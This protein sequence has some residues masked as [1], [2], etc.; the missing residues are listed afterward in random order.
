MPTHAD[1]KYCGSSAYHGSF[2]SRAEFATNDGGMYQVLY[3]VGQ[4]SLRNL[5]AYSPRYMSFASILCFCSTSLQTIYRHV[6]NLPHPSSPRTC[7]GK[8]SLAPPWSSFPSPACAVNFRNRTF[9]ASSP[10]LIVPAT[11]PPRPRFLLRLK[12]VKQNER[13]LCANTLGSPLI[14]Q[15]TL[16]VL[17][18]VLSL[19]EHQ[20][21]HTDTQDT[22]R[23]TLHK[24]AED[25]KGRF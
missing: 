24:E 10:C 11:P 22:Y 3:R 21:K 23:S 4:S 14:M 25:L 17:F 8:G 13:L 19:F 12:R 9:S 2:L 20:D 15:V 18:Q 6:A 5:S 1:Y 7:A 16:L